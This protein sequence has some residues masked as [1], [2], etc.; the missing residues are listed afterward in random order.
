MLLL[1]LIY[2]GSSA[3]LYNDQQIQVRNSAEVMIKRMLWFMGLRENLLLWA[4]YLLL[5]GWAFWL[6]KK[7]QVLN[8]KFVYLP[9]IIFES[10]IYALFFGFLVG[11]LTERST[12][13]IL[14][15][16]KSQAADMGTKMTLAVGAGIYEELL[17]RFILISLLVFIFH[18]LSGSTHV[19]YSLLAVVL[20]AVLFSGFHYLGNREVFMFE[21]FLFR[22]YAGVILGLLFVLRGIAVASYTHAIYNL[23]LIFR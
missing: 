12:L 17:F 21:S 22:F 19:V 1:L 6:A 9:Y 20:S 5:L 4:A 3:A 8:F 2:E 18:K 14:L 15:Q 16:A 23:L 7:Q 10:T 11:Q 13:S